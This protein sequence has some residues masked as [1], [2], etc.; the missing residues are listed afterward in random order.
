MFS[1]KLSNLHSV[2]VEN[3]RLLPLLDT[4]DCDKDEI[5]S[6]IV[7]LSR[8][9]Q[10][11]ELFWRKWY[12]Y[13]LIHPL[14]ATAY[15]AECYMKAY[16]QV[17]LMR[18]REDYKSAPFRTGIKRKAIW[19]QSSRTVTSLWK[20][21]QTADRMRVPYDFFCFSI[22]LDTE[23]R[24]RLHLATPAQL[25]QAELLENFKAALSRKLKIELMVSSEPYFTSGGYGQCPILED[26]TRFVVAQIKMRGEAV[27]PMSL[28]SAIYTHKAISREVALK[29]FPEASVLAADKL[30]LNWCL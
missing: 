24:G 25:Y 20:A 21:R 9:N 1:S 28:R 27:L 14:D 10:E 22:I 18:G 4:P 7:G 30:Q 29:Y 11:C 26:Y 17:M 19:E 23:T 13:R 3:E 16:A 12:D 6:K 15:F 5:V 8:C 2:F